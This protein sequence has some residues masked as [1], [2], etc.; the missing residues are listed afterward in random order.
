[1]AQDLIRRLCTVD[2]SRRLGNISGGAF[3][4]KCHA[5]FNGIVWDDVY[6]RR[7]RGP[8]IPHLRFPGDAQC[9]DVYPEDDVGK[10]PYTDEMARQYDAYF[11]DF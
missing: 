4:V 3:R 8:I 7:Q 2:R 5:W 10:E 1:M 9:F 6:H 11:V